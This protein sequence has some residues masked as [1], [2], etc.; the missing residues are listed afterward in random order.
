MTPTRNLSVLGLGLGI[1]TV[2]AA[3]PAF[4]A[5]RAAIL[6]VDAR[7][8]PKN[9]LHAHETLP[10]A[11]GPLVLSYAKW[12]PGEHGP[13][14]P[15]EN[16]AGL[17]ISAGG[18]V[19]AWKRDAEDMYAVLVEVPKG[20]DTV[21]VDLDFLEPAETK[22][23]SSGAST[24]AELAL[25][26]WNH[27]LLYPKGTK[28]DDWN[29]TAS[30]ALPKGWKYGTALPVAKDGGDKIAFQMVS[31]TT[32]V[33]S[34]VLAGAHTRVLPLAD[35]PPV[36]IF[37]A[38][39]S[40]DDL[41]AP[42]PTQV[43]LAKLVAEARA[44]FR[45]EHYRGYTFLLTLSDHVASFGLE[46]HESSDDRVAE[47][48]LVDDDHR[49]LFAGLLPHEYVHS[50]NGKHRRPAELGIGG[51]D[52][53]MHGELLWVYE[54][55]TEYLGNVLTA[56]SGLRTAE[57]ARDELALT[58]AEMETHRGR[59]WRPLADTAVAAQIL[60]ASPVEGSSFRRGVDFYAEGDLI[61]LEA[62]AIIRQ[63]TGGKASLDDFCRRFHGGQSGPP[64]VSPYSLE[65][66][67][68]GLNAVAPNDWNAF[69]QSRVYATSDKAPLGGIEA[70]GWTLTYGDKPTKVI[71][72]YET[73]REH[74][75]LRFSIGIAVDKDGVIR[76]VIP[77]SPAAVAGVTPGMKLVAV[78]RWHWNKDRLHDAVR[79]TKK[80]R[81]LE[82]LLEGGEV[83]K[84]VT[85]KYDGGE[86]YPRLERVAS[87]PDL[88]TGILTGLSQ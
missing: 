34:P 54:G 53:P 17:K 66:V 29:V 72:S 35:K 47:R 41:D 12:I 60:Y 56:R 50:W 83:M 48:S 59:S 71:A 87:K 4:A 82:L 10:A 38:A 69:F 3:A 70:A 13:T 5:G 65:D 76:D 63:K 81:P 67:V 32:L 25:V 30:I 31:L 16:V 18:K 68:A 33:D 14:G 21:T 19:L 20:A 64:S 58:A 52:T 2:L 15:L 39:D 11:P 23:F 75:D 44:L 62:D 40:D 27:V 43:A 73:A 55:L 46:H 57:E 24:T 7:D 80:Q 49:R 88:L 37:I 28:S 84:S 36:R 26:S 86:R 74:I 22:G 51:Y 6:D 61:W 79:D 85:L 8:V 9:L 77:G 1:V 42:P 78:N 45:A